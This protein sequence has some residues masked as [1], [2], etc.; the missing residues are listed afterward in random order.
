MQP[1]QQAR[2]E[3]LDWLR[4]VACL[5]VIVIHVTA[6]PLALAQSAG[7]GAAFL[8]ALNQS[9][10]FAIPAFVFV[11]GAALFYT[12][13]RAEQPLGRAFWRR[14]LIRVVIP[15]VFWTLVY[16]A[17]SRQAG[18]GGLVRAL[19]TGGGFYHLY[20]V[21]LIVQFY[22]LLPLLR[23]LAVG[24]GRRWPAVLAALGLGH[25]GLM[26]LSQGY[27]QPVGH[28]LLDGLMGVHDRLFPFWLFYFAL[29]AAVGLHPETSRRLSRRL[30][31]PALG[32]AALALVWML[33]EVRTALGSLDITVAYAATTLRPSAALYSLAALVLLFTPA[34]GRGRLGPWI[35]SLAHHSYGIYLIHP[36]LLGGLQRAIALLD[37]GYT[38][39]VVAGLWA[40]VTAG[41]WAAAAL[42]SRL[43]VGRLLLGRT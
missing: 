34:P 29:G 43:P 14:R 22:L 17:L 40:V 35:D 5:G 6:A 10:R 41:A 20:F 33:T 11:A 37:L 30:R 21:F 2:I 38:P 23:P 18:A 28:P 19:L 4:A 42:G 31:L 1:A 13:G 32:A 25:L 8:A 9:A 24:L 39:S 3:A 7:T 15:Y 16:M 26:L 27:T 12:Y 36:L